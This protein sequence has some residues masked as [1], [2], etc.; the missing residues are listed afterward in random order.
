MNFTDG[1]AVACMKL[2]EDLSYDNMVL[3]DT[4]SERP[5]TN[6]MLVDKARHCPYDH[7]MSF[8]RINDASLLMLCRAGGRAN[9]TSLRQCD[10]GGLLH[11]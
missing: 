6:V 11:F 4:L 9:G 8:G 3:A 10:V 7:G 5:Y 2:W 1:Y